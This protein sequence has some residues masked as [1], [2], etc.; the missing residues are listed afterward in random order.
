M[1]TKQASPPFQ[2]R[3]SR[4]GMALIVVLGSLIFLS[5]LLLAFL[6]SVKTELVTSKAYADNNAV[7]SLVN[8]SV[9]IVMSQ[10]RQASTATS[11][12]VQ[13][14]WTSQPG[15]I[16]TFTNTGTADQSYKLYS[17]GT[18]QISGALDPAAEAG[19]LSNWYQK[20][21]LYTDL[22]QPV[23]G[24]YPILN[25]GA[26]PTV[27][28][29]S[30]TGAPT[31]ATQS[32]PMPVQ[33][34]YVLRDGTLIAPTPGSTS[35][36]ATV[37]S[38]TTSNPIVGRIA[39]WTDDES[40]K[41]NINTASEGEYWDVPH[42]NNVIDQN[43]GIFQ[44]IKNEFQGYPGHPAGVSLSTVFPS[45]VS[46]S[47]AA[48][49]DS[50]YKTAPRIAS[51]GSLN[52]TVTASTTLSPVI[53]DSD[54]L[55]DSAE[56]LIFSS[57]SSS[58]VRLTNPQPLPSGILPLTQDDIEK[59]KFFITAHSRSPETTL[60]G[61][62]KVVCW[63][64]SSTND[65]NHRSAFDR[66]I[67]FCG[68]V[69]NK[70]YYF[71]RQD[72]DSTTNDY[73]N[74][75]R[76]QDIYSYL[77][78]LMATNVPG[79]GGNLASKFGAD[80][81]QIL[82]EIFD[83]IRCT[84]LN[85]MNLPS[86]S[87]QYAGGTGPDFGKS[88]VAP[89]TIGSTRGF[90][91]IV[92][93]G[94]VGLWLICTADPQDIVTGAGHP[95]P[96]GY[97]S[98]ND[99]ATN[100]TLAVGTPLTKDDVANPR[101]KQIRI[102]AALILEPFTPMQSEVPMHSDVEILV[103]GL[104][105]WT[106][107]GD[108]DVGPV[109]FSFPD[110]SRQTYTDAGIF[111][112][113]VAYSYFGKMDAGG[114]FGTNWA[115]W[116]RQIRQRNFGSTGRLAK[117]PSFS[118]YLG[119]PSSVMNRQYPFVSEP[120][121]INVR[122]IAPP[123][124]ARPL[125][126]PTLTFTGTPI[127]ITIRKRLPDPVTGIQTVIQTL[128][129]SFPA[130][131][132]PAPVLP[133]GFAWTFQ[134]R[135]CG[136]GPSANSGRFNPPSAAGSAPPLVDRNNDVIYS[137]VAAQG[138]PAQTLDPRFIAMSQTVSAGM[139]SVHPNADGIKHFAHSIISDP[140]SG[141]GGISNVNGNTGTLANLGPGNF[142]PWSFVPCPKVPCPAA[143][144]IANG[145]WD[146]GVGNLMDGGYLNAPEQ[147]DIVSSVSNGTP[148]YSP[149]NVANTNFTSPSRM[150][151]SPGM[152]GSLPTGFKRN[153][154]WQTLLFRRQPGH[155]DYP[156]PAGAFINNPDYLMMDLFW[157]PVV[158]PYAISEPLSTAGKINMNYQIVPF[159][160]IERSTGLY[161]V[162]KHEKVISV[163][164]TDY[165]GAYKNIY[166]TIDPNKN[167]RRDVK[168]P[169]TLTQFQ[170]RFSGADGAKDPNGQPFY[171]FRTPS[172]IC[173]MHIIPDDA[174]PSTT[175][176]SSLDGA[177]AT[178]WASHALTG[179]NTRERIYTTLYPRLTT[180]SN[181][182]RVHY[183]VQTLKKRPN[184]T[185]NQWTE[186]NDF[187]TGE[188]RGSVLFERYIDVNDTAHPLPDYATNS[189]AASLETYYQFRVISVNRFD[190]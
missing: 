6:S 28:G 120:V 142:Y 26:S 116:G 93:I 71:Q 49:F 55:Y 153:Q 141:M 121:T 123:P 167:Y 173:D 147:G 66:L 35:V 157:M 139:F 32:A 25:P 23:S 5:A 88:E 90:G 85:D 47:G 16:R 165:N 50:F 181:T 169:E 74:I 2:R 34:L 113:G 45:L 41:V 146:N 59:A 57:T 42:F 8:T 151:P 10:I 168:I 43:L 68:T 99:P 180:R 106:V 76:N 11:S 51:G 75:Q 17:S 4:R 24:I 189:G 19:L 117:D 95:N 178:Y 179:D 126:L 160:Y 30:V 108:A 149:Q 53:L 21:A 73:I 145:D 36:S 171:A 105:N 29:Y 125:I 86:V 38:A 98:S 156:G 94:E 60:F 14:C 37:V 82:T 161:A 176:K 111:E 158:E 67:A 159:T 143:A 134:A 20:A 40:C 162:L 80:S 174:S 127:T 119:P 112:L 186:G 136:V 175:S 114:N 172:E 122:Q 13:D 137:L 46:G 83:Y 39:F 155:P 58:N 78:T 12:G 7:N 92:S 144:A 190:P 61:T 129:L 65:T 166:S 72:K 44:P 91:R 31:T 96:Q 152:F 56:E 48:Q 135:G 97:Q 15:L 184:S 63:P 107:Q 163:P 110:I 187:V 27:Q 52:L 102:E 77:H 18:M 118:T 138:S 133:T 81:D 22:N 182:F 185:V 9:S 79:F 124:P 140:A 154:G 100:L 64:I 115:L 54:R 183:R 3:E 33:W 164:T 130:T 148:Y 150:I 177:M 89:I 70:L 84:N 103:K 170:Q 188:G 62:P 109:N 69:N 87:F 132:A 104:E 1:K 101:T 128:N 131:A